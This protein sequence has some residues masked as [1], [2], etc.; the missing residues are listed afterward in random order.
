M[1]K[2]KQ[3]EHLPWYTISM[4]LTILGAVSIIMLFVVYFYNEHGIVFWGIVISWVV[5]LLVALL[6]IGRL[7]KSRLLLGQQ[8]DKKIAELQELLAKKK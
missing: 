2:A 8:K 1:K 7:E 4:L 3:R 6:E 5:I